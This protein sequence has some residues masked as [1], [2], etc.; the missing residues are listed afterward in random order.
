MCFAL[1]W[2]KRGFHLWQYYNKGTVP[3][4]TDTTG[5]PVDVDLNVWLGDIGDESH[6]YAMT[7]SAP[8][9]TKSGKNTYTSLDGEIKWIEKLSAL[10]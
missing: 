10:L 7:Q 1:Q 3:G 4:I 8:T 9:C 2:D 5:K 6:S